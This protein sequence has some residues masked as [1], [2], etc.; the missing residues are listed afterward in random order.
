MNFR[1]M[2]RISWK[3]LLSN[4]MRSLLTMLG[5]IIGV[6][7]V[8]VMI[9]ISAGT[10]ATI[11]ES[12]SGLGTNLVFIMGNISRAGPGAGFQGMQ[13]GLVYD[14]MTAIG[15]RI[16]GVAG[17]TVEQQTSVTVKAGNTTLESI[18]ILGATPDY[19]T[20]RDVSVSKGRFYNEQELDRASKVVVL[21]SGVAEELF[22]EDDPIGQSIYASNVKLTV[23]GVLAEKGLVSGTD[24][25]Q[26]IY[27]PITVV[28]KKFTPSMFARMTGDRVR[29]IIV[30]VDPDADMDKVIEQITLLLAN[31][32]EVSLDALDFTMLT[33]SDIIETQE[34]TTS[35][36]RVLLAWVAG[37]SLIVGGIGIMN[38]MLVSVT[39]RTREIGLRQ[40]VGATPGDIQTQ[41]LTEAMM[42]SLMGGLIGVIVGVLGGILFGALSDMRTVIEAYSIILSFTSAAL[43]GIAFGYLPAR[44]AAQLD[45]IESLRHE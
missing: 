2:V 32:H 34:S 37:V 29:Q 5:V 3:S 45:P 40:A 20:V 25:D 43:I 26:Q 11:S 41:F 28:F 27:T 19:P 16:N 24:F 14:D 10:E 13:G 21:G 31:R 7:A 15:D 44:R 35:S 12:I 38:I 1:E 6:A 42:L 22:G 8:I 4:K 23:I 18:T 30:S 36:F 9:S 33:Q 39:E 17:V